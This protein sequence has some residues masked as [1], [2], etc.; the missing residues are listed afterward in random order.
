MPSAVTALLVVAAAILAS[1]QI[2]PPGTPTKVYVQMLVNSIEK[3]DGVE[4]QFE[5]DFYLSLFWYDPNINGSATSFDTNNW[6]TPDLD[7]QDTNGAPEKLLQTTEYSINRAITDTIPDADHPTDPWG[8][9]DQR[10]TGAFKTPL[11]LHN[12]PF[13]NQ[14]LRIV[15]E[16]ANWDNKTLHWLPVVPQAQFESLLTP[17]GFQVTSWEP[18]HNSLI[19]KDQFYPTYNA[20]YSR[21]EVDVLMARQPSYYMYKVVS[22]SVLLVYMC[23]AI[24]ALE[25]EE[26][27]RMMGTLTVFLA[28]ISFV[29]VASQDLPKVPY[30]TR[31]DKF[32]FLSFLL[33]AVMMFIHSGQYLF[34]EHEEEEKENEAKKT[35]KSPEDGKVV[36]E[37]GGHGTDKG[38]GKEE[39]SAGTYTRWKR[40]CFNAAP[41]RKRDWVFV[42]GLSLIYA[43]GVGAIFS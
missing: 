3:I 30:L 27:D 37:V 15:F 43:I 7:F 31:I 24:F 4:Q 1:A 19:M 41:V 21:F 2:Q 16:S 23:I 32:S 36:V 35:D 11:D 9:Y 25:V 22:G 28:L 14:A 18:L 5:A 42:I 10:Y 20:Y 33:V 39:H 12:F 6:W 26:A 34:R 38:H 13:D 40:R 29:F 17:Q 8:E